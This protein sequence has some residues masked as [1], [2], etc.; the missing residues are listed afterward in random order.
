MEKWIAPSS[1]VSHFNE[2]VHHDGPGGPA[3]LELTDFA[4]KPIGG[5]TYCGMPVGKDWLPAPAGMPHC[6]ICARHRV[7]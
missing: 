7:L 1:R 3:H 2:G 4:D 6:D 5:R